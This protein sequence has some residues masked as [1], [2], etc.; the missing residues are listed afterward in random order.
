MKDQQQTKDLLRR[1]FRGGVVERVP[2]NSDDAEVFLALAAAWLDPRSNYSE[3][4]VNEHLREWIDGFATH[5]T[6]DH[7]TL[8]RH[9][10]DAN[11]LLRDGPGSVYTANQSV[12]SSVIEPEARSVHPGDILAEVLMEKQRRKDAASSGTIG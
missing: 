8:R 7:V 9:L 12:I 1:L 4:E 10:V 5:T 6:M 3:A 11:F 2:K